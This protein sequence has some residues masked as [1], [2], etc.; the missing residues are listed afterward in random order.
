MLILLPKCNISIHFLPMDFVISILAGS[1][2]W[3]GFSTD[4]CDRDIL[5]K[6]T[7]ALVE[8]KHKVEHEV[9]SFEGDRKAVKPKV[10]RWLGEVDK[11]MVE[12]KT[13]QTN[14]KDY[15]RR[16]QQRSCSC[17]WSQRCKFSKKVGMLLKEV[18]ILTLAGILISDVVDHDAEPSTA[19]EAK[20]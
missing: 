19:Y 6:E 5:E 14:I 9:Q 4:C 20:T 1:C 2:C 15:D 3:L 16:Q 8:L 10:K 18:R 11:C 12:V 13:L 7:Q 17:H